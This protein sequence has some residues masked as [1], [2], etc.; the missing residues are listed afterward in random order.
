MKLDAIVRFASF[1]LTFLS[2][3]VLLFGYQ[4]QPVDWTV[5]NFVPF[6]ERSLKMA[7]QL[8]AHCATWPCVVKSGILHAFI[9]VSFAVAFRYFAMISLTSS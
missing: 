9:K 4:Q 8:Y 5:M 1:F 6:G 3:F 7:T 2:L